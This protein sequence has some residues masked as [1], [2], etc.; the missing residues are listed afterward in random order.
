MT[1]QNKNGV[2]TAWIRVD[3][4]SPIIVFVALPI[5]FLT[6]CSMNGFKCDFITITLI[7]LTSLIVLVFLGMVL[8]LPENLTID[9]RGHLAMKREEA[10]RKTGGQSN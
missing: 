2:K 1:E 10:K 7:S 9:G 6:F 3:V 4:S 5:I 8:F